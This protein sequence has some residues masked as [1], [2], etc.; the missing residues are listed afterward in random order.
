MKPT[1][2]LILM[3]LGVLLLG[4]GTA[5]SLTQ[6]EQ[7]TIDVYKQCRMGVVNITTTELGFD[8]F[9]QPYPKKGAGSGV[10]VDSRGFVVTNYHVVAG[11]KRIEVTFGDGTRRKAEI[12]GQAPE[13]DLAVLRVENPPGGALALSLGNSDK[14]E[15]GQKVMAIGNPF[16]LGHTLTTGTVSAL[17]SRVGH[18]GGVMIE[19]VI[20]TDAAINPGNSGGPLLDS[21]GRVIGINTSILSPTGAYVGIGFAIP[22][23]QAKTLMPSLVSPVPRLAGWGI[24][25]LLFLALFLWIR[26]RLKKAPAVPRG[27]TGPRRYH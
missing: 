14:V 19:N 26:K 6:E 15:V 8:F 3:L 10:V 21:A 4:P 1:R 23:N 13:N 18:T 2:Y 22:V 20:Q 27:E 25:L 12:A 17:R 7:N 16:G 5:L 11:A 24:A 9:L